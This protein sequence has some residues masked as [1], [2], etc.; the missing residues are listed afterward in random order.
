M[1]YIYDHAFY[2]HMHLDTSNPNVTVRYVVISDHILLQ[3]IAHSGDIRNGITHIFFTQILHT[4]IVQ[5]CLFS[6]KLPTSYRTSI[7]YCFS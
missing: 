5:R 3:N 4:R 6:F 7:N 2:K 1:S